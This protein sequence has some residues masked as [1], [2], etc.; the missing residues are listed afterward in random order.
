MLVLWSGGCD[1]TLMLHDLAKNSTEYYP[2]R[3]ISVIHPQIFA[4]KEQRAA[5][6]KVLKWMK[7]HGHHIFHQEVEIKHSGEKVLCDGSAGAYAGDGISQYA[8]WM[9]SAVNYLLAEEDLYLGYIQ[10][11]DI[12]GYR[13]QIEESFRL[14]LQ[15]MGKKG[16]IKFPLDR[17]SKPEIIE[18]LKSR[19]LYSLTWHCETPNRKGQRCGT[20]H[21]CIKHDVSIFEAQ[22]KKT[23]SKPTEIGAK[24]RKARRKK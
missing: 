7:K 23:R 6:K 1:S 3:T 9:L 16:E 20:C 24:R 22:I 5:R 17:K 4:M 11:D 18:S 21:P 19:G 2:I 13:Y 8:I 10:G 14:L 15:I 12:W